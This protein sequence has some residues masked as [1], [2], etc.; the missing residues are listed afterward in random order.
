MSLGLRF[1]NP[2]FSSLEPARFTQGYTVVIYRLG[3][4]D[5]HSV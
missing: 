4:E 5:E 1:Q 3:V 2:W